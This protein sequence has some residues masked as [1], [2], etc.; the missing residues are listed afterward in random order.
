MYALVIAD[1]CNSGGSGRYYIYEAIDGIYEVGAIHSDGGLLSAQ[2][3][4]IEH[5]IERNPRKCCICH[6]V[7]NGNRPCGRRW[8]GAIWRTVD[9]FKTHFYAA[10]HRRCGGLESRE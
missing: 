7:W 9:N 5:S 3:V 8:L 1:A 2:S 6:L 10:D 4:P